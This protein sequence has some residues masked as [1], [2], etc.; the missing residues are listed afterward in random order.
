MRMPIDLA[1]EFEDGGA[2]RLWWDGEDRYHV[3]TW[4][5]RR[6]RRAELDPD[7]RNL[8]EV[9]RLNNLR[10][11]DEAPDGDGLSEPAGDALEIVSLAILGGMGL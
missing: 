1:V 8:L 10:Y 2:Q 9:S 7:H 6:L 11:A 5:G 3:F 4:P